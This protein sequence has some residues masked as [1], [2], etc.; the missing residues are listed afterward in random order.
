[1]RSNRRTDTAPERT[2][3]AEL[4]RRGLRF[5]KDHPIELTVRARI[6]PDI[7]FTRTKVAVFVDGCFWHRCPVHG[8]MPKSN[9]DY[10]E[11]KLRE[12]VA[13]DR[14]VDE[15]LSEHGWTVVRL[16]EHEEPAKAADRVAEAVSRGLAAADPEA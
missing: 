9:V 15:V 6:R 11:P 2:L 8:T 7:V 13:R 16:W 14:R 3:R 5:R 10:W 4:H 12:N 1:M